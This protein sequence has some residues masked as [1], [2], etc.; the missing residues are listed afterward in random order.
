M[1]LPNIH[2]IT[3]T[4]RLALQDAKLSADQVKFISSHATATKMGDVIES[5][6]IYNIY[7]DLPYVTALKSYMGHTMSACGAI[8]TI[9]TLYMMAEGIIIPTLNL[10]TVDERCSMIRHTK[11]LREQ[12]IQIA[13]IQNFAFGGVNTCLI[14][15]KV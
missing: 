3:E 14:I 7:K 9:M 11:E 8:E 6:A 1:I 2:G 12:E 15:K 5:K 10:Q 4:L 13:S